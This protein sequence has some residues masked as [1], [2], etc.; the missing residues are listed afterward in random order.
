MNT[1]DAL[2]VFREEMN[3]EAAPYL[4]SDSWFFRRLDEAQKIFCRLTDGIEDASTAAIVEATILTGDEWVPLDK[5]I[6]K[7]REVVNAATGRSLYIYNTEEASQRGLLF[8]GVPGEPRVLVSGQSKD[9]LRVWPMPNADMAV[10]LRV[11]RL[12][13][14]SLT[15]AGD[16]EFE[17]D[18]Q[19]HLAL[20]HWVKSCAYGKEDA[21]T[22]NRSKRD[23][24]EQRFNAYCAMAKREQSRHRKAVSTVAY[25]GL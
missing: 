10:R 14:V 15:D 24:Y 25:G 18:E 16:E 12:P 4:W 19:H 8:D 6:L 7:V 17:I 21:E 23:D 11:Y 22:F 1:T 20:L 5:R 9:K 13:L 2:A 3:D